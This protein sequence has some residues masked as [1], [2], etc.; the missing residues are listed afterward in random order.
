LEGL[1]GKDF[2]PRGT[3]IVT[4]RPLILQLMRISDLHLH[5]ILIHTFFSSLLI[6]LT[7]KT[8]QT[9]FTFID[10]K[11]WGEFLHKPRKQYFD[12][13]EIKRE[14][15]IETERVAGKNKG[16]SPEPILLKIYSPNVINLTLVDTP[17]IARVL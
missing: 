1:V 5:G 6:N 3:D 2:L 9:F 4:R 7:Y 15:E 12:F 14:I 11:E 8:K 16:I 17:G 10:K 13:D